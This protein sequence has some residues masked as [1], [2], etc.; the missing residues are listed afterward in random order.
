MT[1]GAMEWLE[2]AGFRGFRVSVVTSA[3]TRTTDDFKVIADRYGAELR[4]TR[5]RP[6]GRGADV[7]DELHRR[8]AQQRQVDDWLM[9]HGEQVRTGDLFFHLSADGES[10]PGL[11]LWGA[12]RIVRLIDLFGDVYACPFAIR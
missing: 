3:R 1:I 12:G 9:A 10:L 6:S 4:L 8:P 5:L 2:A 7:R 11:N